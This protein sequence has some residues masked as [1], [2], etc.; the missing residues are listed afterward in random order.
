MDN[1]KNAFYN[2]LRSISSVLFPLITVPYISRILGSEN[3]GKVNFVNSIVSYFILLASLGVSTYAMRE[4]SRVKEDKVELERVSSEI[5][6]INIIAMLTSYIVLFVLANSSEK[7]MQYRMLIFILSLN[8]VGGVIGTDWLNM[9]VGDFKYIA[10]RTMI[11]QFIS[12]AL[13]FIFVRKPGDYFAYAVILVI[14]NSGAQIINIIY[15][16]RYCNI[17]FTFS[18]NFGKH[19]KPIILLFSLLLAQTLQS[20]ID[21]TVL[22]YIKSDRE[23]GQYSMAVKLYTTV[24]KIISAV[25]YVLIPE[26]STL[27]VKKEFSRI[28]K[29]LNDTLLIIMTLAVPFTVGLFMLSKEILVIICGY[30]YKPAAL[31]LSI[32]SLAMLV[33]LFGG[34]FFGN[35]ILLPEAR[36]MQFMMACAI[37]SAFNFVTNMLIIP[38]LGMSGAALTTLGSMIIVFAVCLWRFDN[39]IKLKVEKKQ[40]L[41]IALAA[42]VIALICVGVKNAISS[43]LLVLMVSTI[44]SVC[45]YLTILVVFKNQALGLVFNKLIKQSNRRS[46]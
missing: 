11:F 19:F 6:S 12:V 14:S 28:S 41:S 43:D 38:V 44:T 39:R 34:S 9:A 31:S 33:N 35:L 4:C 1:I 3:V 26:I 46:R 2:T 24:E 7:L 22:G 10:I 5:F 18:L 30:D 40:V 36:E 8:I 29:L 27:Y 16:K 25:A 45:I 20:N 23:V 17:C 37:S 32:L 15:R 21:I 13:M 42:I